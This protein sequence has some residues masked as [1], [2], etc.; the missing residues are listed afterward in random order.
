MY[1]KLKQILVN[2]KNNVPYYQESLKAININSITSLEE[3]RQIPILEKE[4]VRKSPDI[5]L[6]KNFNKNNLQIEFT[7]GSTGKPLK[8]YKDNNEMNIASL[9]LLNSRRKW[10]KNITRMR[11]LKFYAAN[12]DNGKLKYDPILVEKSAISLSLFD[13]SCEKFKFYWNN[14]KNYNDLWA[15]GAPSAILRMAKFLDD[16][17][18]YNIG[19][20][21]F[22]ELTG[23]LVF[24]EQKKFMKEVFKCPIVNHY[25]S[26]EF[27]GIAYECGHGCM[28]VYD[29]Y[30]HVEVINGN[31]E[32]AGYG[33]YGEIVVTGLEKYAMPLIRYK[34]GDRVRL[35]KSNF[36]CGNKSDVI[37]VEGGRTTDYI[38]T[39][40]GDH[41]NP[42]LIYVTAT[43]INISK[44][45]CIDQFQVI[46]KSLTEFI[47]NLSISKDA[48]KCYIE[49][50]FYNKM[51]T[52]VRSDVR[53]RFNYMHEI[54]QDP[55]SGKYKYFYSDII[56]AKNIN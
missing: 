25:G 41:I 56:P 22:I 4:T 44:G 47:I 42:I 14:L 53:L 8:L 39:E 35:L 50:M 3:F 10:I 49:Q 34:L 38:I 13:L 24:E 33:D 9:I 20:I 17:P 52:Y 28:H 6:S 23:E 27:W 36:P 32:M 11:L 21:K 2:A 19:N 15:F 55:I 37:E 45:M 29:K 18:E 16:N 7:S 5:F 12:L 1:D 46:Q 31:G 26:R 30:V 43:E 48:E 40:M 51:R 54:P